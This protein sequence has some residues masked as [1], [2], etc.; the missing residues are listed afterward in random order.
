MS[1]LRIQDVYLS[2]ILDPNFSIPDPGFRVKKIPGSRIR[3]RIRIRIKEF[4]YSSYLKFDLGSII[5][6]P[7]PQHW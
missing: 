1:V 7:D 2:R 6:D 4:K 5:P 3:I